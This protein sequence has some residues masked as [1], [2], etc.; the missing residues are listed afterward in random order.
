MCM[1]Y[2]LLI[3]QLEKRDKCRNKY[4]FIVFTVT[5]FSFYKTLQTCM[6]LLYD[7]S[8]N[9]G[10]IFDCQLCRYIELK[11]SMYLCNPDYLGKVLELFQADG[12]LT[13]YL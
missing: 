7:F 4:F 1:K 2:I 3:L 13:G 11:G 6:S 5:E 10:I 12:D 9:V 8:D